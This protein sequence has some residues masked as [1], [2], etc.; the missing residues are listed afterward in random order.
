MQEREMNE[1]VAKQIQEYWDAYV[2][3]PVRTY[4]DR[5]FRMIFKDKE[6]LLQLYNALHETSYSNPDD[7]T[8]NT[9]ENAVYL[10]MKNDISFILFGQLSL[11]EHQSTWNPNIPL[12]DLLY[13]AKLYEKLIVKDNLYGTKLLQIPSPKFI[14]FYNGIEERPEREVLKLSDA[15]EPSAVEPDLELKVLVL[16]INAGYNENI[17]ENCQTLKE[18]MEFVG[19]VREYDKK[20]PFPQAVNMAVDTCIEKGILADFLRANKAEVVAMSIFE[21]DEAKQRAFDKREG[22]EDGW[23]AGREAGIEAGME[24]G[25]ETGR[26]SL[27]LHALKNGS[28]K[29]TIASVMGIP[30]EEVESVAIGDF[31]KE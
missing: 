30:L 13:V 14:V 23:K 17:K 18:Y 16:N 15:Y 2:L 31:S 12:R 5:V 19:Y 21:Y 26:K 28:S 3:N 22:F 1:I 8:I 20:M 6:E 7:L 10:G 27:I 9:L 4:K 29:E 25:M 24:A 11:Y